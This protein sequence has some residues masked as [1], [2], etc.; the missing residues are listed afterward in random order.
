M[1]N[2]SGPV[3]ILEVGARRRTYAWPEAAQI[4]CGEPALQRLIDAGINTLLNCA[5]ETNQDGGGRERQQYSGD[6][7]HQQHAIRYAFGE[8]RHGARYLSTYSQGLTLDG[9]FLDC[10]SAYDRL[11]RLAQ[12]QVGATIWRYWALAKG[13]RTEVIVLYQCIAGIRPVRPGFAVC[14]IRPQLAGLGDLDLTART[15]RGPIHLEAVRANNGHRMRVKSSTDC[16]ISII[17]SDQ[18]TA[19]SCSDWEGFIP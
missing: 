9:Y 10:W 1:R 19:K 5:Q 2:A 6:V 15:P 4:R 14:E 3:T 13:G 11:A 16:E 7:G 18:K 8:Y 17:V 12:R